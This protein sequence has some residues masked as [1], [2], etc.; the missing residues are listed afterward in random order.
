MVM[1]MPWRPCRVSVGVVGCVVG[2]NDEA[3][4]LAHGVDGVG[5]EV[6]EDLADVV[7]E[8]EDARLGGVA[9]L[10]LDVGV[11][12]TALI[13]IEDGVDEVGC[14]DVGGAD[15]L[16]MEAERLGGDLADAG[17]FALRRLD[18]VA[19]APAGR[20]SDRAMR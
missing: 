4:A 14:G 20:S 6:V 2:A 7:F 15:G 11:G 5:D 3:A 13:E 16:T 18:V 1:R 19:R 8:A 12:E 9:G 17:E 10:D